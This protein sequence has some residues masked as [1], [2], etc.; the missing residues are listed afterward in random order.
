MADVDPTPANAVDGWNLMTM[1]NGSLRLRVWQ[2]APGNLLANFDSSAGAMV[3]DEWHHYTLVANELTTLGTR[4]VTVDYYRDGA[5]LNQASFSTGLQMGD[6]DA[7]FAI[8]NTMW[9]GELLADY[10]RVELHN[11]AMD[12]NQVM[13][14]YNATLIPEPSTVAL[15]LVGLLAIRGLRRL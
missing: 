5:P 4:T 9:D 8:G 10:G 2:E 12:A 6:S 14:L 15:A 7:G 13:A 11:V 1:G 3:Q